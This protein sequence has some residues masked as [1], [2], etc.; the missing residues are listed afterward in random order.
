MII[1][2]IF[3]PRRSILSVALCAAALGIGTGG[4]GGG[5]GGGGWGGWGGWGG[6]LSFSQVPAKDDTDMRPLI[7]APEL[8]KDFAW[9][10]TDQ[11]LQ[12]SGALKGQVV[13]MDF[14]T[15]CCI[16]CMHVLPD[17]D[18][19]EQKY[20]DQP[21]V[22]L[23][24]HSAKYDN[25]GDAANIRAAI[26]RYEIHHPVIVDENHKIWESYD[27]S[28]WPTLIVV[29]TDGRIIGGVSGEGHR[30]LLENV[31][32]KALADGT[33]DGTIAKAPLKLEREGEIRAASGLSFPSKVI[34]DKGA[35]G[36]TATKRLFIVDANHNRIVITNYPTADG[37]A[38]VQEIIGSGKHGA[39]DGSFAE[40]SFNRPQG[41]ALAGGGNIL[42][43]ADTV[44]HLI[45][46][47]DLAKKS[48]T[49]VLG[50]GKQVFDHEA[51]KSGREQ[52]LNSPWDVAALGNR[53]YISQAGQHQ[54]FAMNIMS[55]MTEVAAGSSR[56]DIRDGD[57]LSANLAQ[58]SGLA[59][60]AKNQILYFADS[61]VS[62]VR[63]LD[64]R[65]KKVFTVIGHGLF[66]FGDVD[67][68][69]NQARFQHA[70]GV[71]LTADGTALLV[72][73]TYNHKIK[74]VD[75][76]THTSTTIAGSGKAG[77]S[78][79]DGSAQFFE[80]A[81]ISVANEH[82]AFIAD[83]NNHRIVRL[84]PATGAWKELTIEG[85]AAPGTVDVAIDPDARDAGKVT[86]ASG[87]AVALHLGL[88]LP[89][90]SHLTPGAPISIKVTDGQRTLYT[91]SLMGDDSA[92][93]QPAIATTIPAEA[94]AAQPNQLYVMLYYTRCMDG[95]N[96]VC[97]PAK[98]AWKMGVEFGGNVAEIKL[99]Q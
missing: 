12:F 52:G 21:V 1:G 85:L 23:G 55:S 99:A 4:C 10:N 53:L 62:A 5:G 44:N 56:E 83:T 59:M 93:K 48:V 67:G 28:S 47:V 75:L 63:G 26:Q 68:D 90:G 50:T 37:R 41:A 98:G 95:I 32:D 70:L 31:I 30:E 45:R 88:K 89:L 94:L 40:A 78:A 36:E 91:G 57:A 73:D 15:Y 76:A 3:P 74:R 33:K 77:T 51:G 16:N 9:L 22:I 11:P 58:P 66:D 18:Y 79:A 64:L 71:S 14:W 86:L 60:D 39:D 34:V 43:V 46:R 65:E 17:L 29:G 35:A 6:R 81:N 72:A 20:K 49:T 96:A 7:H 8:P 2:R 80:P 54:I 24:V 13:V 27:V 82:E 69:A 25:E 19:L 92:A 38:V 84:D 87:K 97:T 42:W 61:E